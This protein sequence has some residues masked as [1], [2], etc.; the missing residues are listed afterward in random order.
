M[1]KDYIEVFINGVPVDDKIKLDSINDNI[2]NY[3]EEKKKENNS[4]VALYNE[5]EQVLDVLKG[6]DE[7]S[8]IHGLSILIKEYPSDLMDT[9]LFGIVDSSYASIALSVINLE[10][11]LFKLKKDKTIGLIK[12]RNQI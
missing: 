8:T 2:I 5:K 12:K 10:Y 11:K 1:G 3:L 6:M 7:F 4:I 9:H